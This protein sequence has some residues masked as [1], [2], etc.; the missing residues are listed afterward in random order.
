MKT[1]L[2]TTS[3]RLALN[4]GLKFGLIGALTGFVL[5]AVWG[6][7]ETV[8][9]TLITFFVIGFFI[10]FLELLF[11]HSRM[12]RL[13]YTLLLLLRSITYFLIILLINFFSFYAYMTI[14]GFEISALSDPQRREEFESVY[15]LSQVSVQ[16]VLFFSLVITFVWQLQPFFGKGVLLNYLLG[17]YHKPSIEWRI[18]MFLDLNDATTIAEQLGSRKYSSFITDFLRDIDGAITRTKGQVFQYVGDEVVIIWS[19]KAG[20]KNN[21]CI[22]VFF[23]A[24]KILE[25]RKAYYQKKYGLLPRFKAAL[26]IGEVTITEIG[27]SKKEIAYHGDTINTT[28]RI[29]ASVNKLGK[30]FLISKPL[31][32][33]LITNVEFEDLGEHSFKGKE[34]RTH[35][36]GY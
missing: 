31:F 22:R 13:P 30:Q 4:L 7:L 5:H 15:F 19:L 35:I 9:Y 12:V 24:Q 20:L 27:V 2:S 32:E 11:A 26:H 8:S 36:F 29:C 25:N 23:L 10:G 21:N 16:W 28:S 14:S 1:I 18:F 6:N 17:K 3:P 33:K 34:E